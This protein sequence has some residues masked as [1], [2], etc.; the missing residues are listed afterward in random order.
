MVEVACINCV[1]K[2]DKTRKSGQ[3]RGQMRGQGK[4]FA[5]DATVICASN[6]HA[7]KKKGV[8]FTIAG[9]YEG[10]R[11]LDVKEGDGDSEGQRLVLFFPMSTCSLVR[12]RLRAA[13]R[14]VCVSP[15][16]SSSIFF[17]LLS[18]HTQRE[19]ERE[20]TRVIV[21]IASI[22]PRLVACC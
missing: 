10:Y 1:K 5:C 21:E 6:T 15:A 22:F 20:L 16:L 9:C 12:E 7:H 14:Q 11:L 8:Y 4:G 18:T 17:F 3:A 13:N 19:R 2:M